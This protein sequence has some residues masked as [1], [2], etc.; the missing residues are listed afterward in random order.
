MRSVERERHVLGC[1]PTE[2]DL[3]RF[4]DAFLE[5]PLLSPAHGAAPARSTRPRTSPPRA[6]ALPLARHAWEQSFERFAEGGR[7]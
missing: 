6:H 3:E 5:P 1:W 4:G 7:R 2:V